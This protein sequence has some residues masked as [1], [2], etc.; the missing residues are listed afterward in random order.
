MLRLSGYSRGVRTLPK[1]YDGAFQSEEFLRWFLIGFQIC[2][3]ILLTLLNAKNIKEQCW[4][5]SAK[6]FNNFIDFIFNE[7]EL[8]VRVANENGKIRLV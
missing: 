2:Y 6:T 5:G 3:S 8:M 4:K 7:L 1:I